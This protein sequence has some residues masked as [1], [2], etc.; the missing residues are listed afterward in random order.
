MTFHSDCYNKD[1]MLT[2][3]NICQHLMSCPC[4]CPISCPVKNPLKSRFL[5]P[6]GHKDRK[7]TKMSYLYILYI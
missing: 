2:N 5:T 4:S 6:S 3:V 1:F 7:D